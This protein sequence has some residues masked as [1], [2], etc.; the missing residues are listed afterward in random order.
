[1]FFYILS[2]I[3]LMTMNFQ[4]LC[5]LGSYLFI[6]IISTVLILIGITFK[7]IYVDLTNQFDNTMFL[8][9]LV[10]FKLFNL[11]NFFELLTFYK[12]FDNILKVKHYKNINK[13]YISS[14]L[15]KQQVIRKTNIKKSVLSY[16]KLII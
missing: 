14:I 3:V 10:W 11:T 7:S 15:T 16:K 9:V 1:M 2:L 13:Q 12:I 5:A 6:F 8:S 4:C